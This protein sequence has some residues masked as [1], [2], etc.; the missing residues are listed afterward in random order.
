M[1]KN[2]WLLLM[3]TGVLVTAQQARGETLPESKKPGFRGCGTYL[4]KDDKTI[5]KN[6]GAILFCIDA[7]VEALD[8]KSKVADKNFVEEL[9][10]GKV[11]EALRDYED[12]EK[13]VEAITKLTQGTDGKAVRQA[14]RDKAKA[15]A[16]EKGA[17][18]DLKNV[19]KAALEALKE[20]ITDDSACV[21]KSGI[22][23]IADKTKGFGTKDLSKDT[24]VMKF[25]FQ[26]KTGSFSSSN[27]ETRDWGEFAN[28]NAAVKDLKGKPERI[29]KNQKFLKALAESVKKY[30][31]TD[32][33]YGKLNKESFLLMQAFVHDAAVVI[34]ASIH[35]E[36]TLKGKKTDAQ[37]CLQGAKQ[38][39][40]DAKS[41][42]KGENYES[43]SDGEGGVSDEG[44]EE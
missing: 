1:K 30:W 18:E 33:A 25:K 4:L 15:K 14:H 20:Y 38:R 10:K 22:T 16:A 43:G 29:V 27:A 34:G 2:M 32:K 35:Y 17:S 41:T 26:L 28:L 3:V 44:S 24:P 19:D 31:S 11:K 13:Y 9:K 6:M 5:I 7:N 42:I 40:A 36:E 21:E 8:A 37:D 39:R 23:E 12:S